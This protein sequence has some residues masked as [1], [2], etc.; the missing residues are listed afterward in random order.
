[1]KNKKCRIMKKR[2]MGAFF[3]ALIMVFSFVPLS[4]VSAEGT[5]EVKATPVDYLV[6]EQI[7][8]QGDTKG[9]LSCNPLSISNLSDDYRLDVN[10]I[11]FNPINSWQ[12]VSSGTDFGK[13]G[14]DEKKISLVADNSHDFVSAYAN[15]GSV[16]SNGEKNISISAKK[17][18]TSIATSEN[19]G[20]FTV[21]IEAVNVIPT[22]GV[23]TQTDGTIL[24]AGDPFP[25]TVTKGDT[26][27]YGDYIYTY[28]KS[29]GMNWNAKVKDTTKSSYGELL[30]EIAGKPMDDMNSTFEDCEFMTTAPKIPNSVSSMSWT[31][32]FCESLTTAPTIPEGVRIMD[33]VFG[34]CHS[35]K[36]APEIPSSVYNMEYAFGACIALSGD[37][38]INASPSLY[39]GCFEETE[40]PIYLKGTAE[41]YEVR[42]AIA[43][44]DKPNRNVEVW[45][46]EI[47][48]GGIY[49]ASD[50]TVY[51]A[52][53]FFP[54]TVTRGDTYEY[55]DY[56]YKYNDGTS[57]MATDWHCEVKDTSKSSYANPLS[58]IAGKPVNNFNSTYINC[59]NLMEAPTLPNSVIDMTDTFYGCTSLTTVTEIPDSVTNM[60]STFQQ[61]TSLKTAPAIPQSVTNM[62][63]TFSRCTSLTT[64]PEIPDSVTEM[65]ST[66]YS[67]TSLKTAPEIPNGVTNM[68]STFSG[69]TSLT[70]APEIPDSVT[71]MGS[72]FQQCTSLT[73]APAIPQSVTDMRYTFRDC[74]SLKTAPEIPD[75]VKDM[76]ATFRG[77][78]SLTG[79][80]IINA[81]PTDYSKCFDRT[82][83]LIYL[84][85]TAGNLEIRREMAKTARNGNVKVYE[86]AVIPEGGKY[87][88][89]SDVT[90]N[91]G[92]YFPTE[93]TTGDEYF[94]GDYKYLYNGHYRYHAMDGNLKLTNESQNGWGVSVQD[95][96]KTSYPEIKISQEIML[97]SLL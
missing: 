61:C 1:M 64:A 69:C 65:T 60:G 67:C 44:E 68:N 29:T 58:E 36:T 95:K 32:Y 85:G 90:L 79:D 93:V 50:G 8:I 33:F 53:D 24:N 15:V 16:A 13:L 59:F 26:Y 12:I 4:H 27:E 75:S 40:K 25:E 37:I 17:G 42:K 55:G 18:V 46:Q 91:A 56:K 52:G 77:C 86:D 6:T 30:S 20:N 63:S 41:N 2:I 49:T 88:T 92:D 74:T 45:E 62:N 87:I 84:K 39:E 38:T 80:I 10:N 21:T 19:V 66:F 35:L 43:K 57:N 3:I 22:G 82:E 5:A 14:K 71:N 94:E 78:T 31:F 72:T 70:T 96:T 83:E 48:E 51:T 54:E 7:N 34:E 28:A 73:T 81:S 89:S 76:Y 23:Y 11:S 97:D 47:P 9:N